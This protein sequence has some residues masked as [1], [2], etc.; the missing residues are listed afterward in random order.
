MNER[1][2][3]K[4]LANTRGISTHDRHSWLM[5]IILATWE[6]ETRRIEVQS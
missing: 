1:F 5:S 2:H 4:F 6:A 3:I